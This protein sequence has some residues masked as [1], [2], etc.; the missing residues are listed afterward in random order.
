MWYGRDISCQCTRDWCGLWSIQSGA[1]GSFV[2]NTDEGTTFNGVAGTT[3][4]LRWTISNGVC[5][6]SFDELTVILDQAPTASNAGTAQTAGSAICGT[7]A[8]LAG[9]TPGVGTGLW[10]ITT[11]D[12]SGAFVDN[13]DPTTDFTGSTEFT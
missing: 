6:D 3:Y 5:S 12:G 1:G 9:N 11:G 8:T 13:T 7:T 10:T 2:L 4:V